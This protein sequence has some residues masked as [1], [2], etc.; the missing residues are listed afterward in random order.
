MHRR[1]KQQ[2]NVDHD[3]EG[4]SDK[5]PLQ[6]HPSPT[7]TVARM[8]RQPVWLLLAIASGACAACNGVFAKLYVS[9]TH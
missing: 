6:P 8:H 9:S 3:G 5:L 2:Q 7:P 4:D 1:K